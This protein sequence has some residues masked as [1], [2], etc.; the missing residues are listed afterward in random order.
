MADAI[1]VHSAP[2]P[3]KV[4]KPVQASPT[5]D[6]ESGVV[7]EGDYVAKVREGVGAPADFESDAA[8]DEK[9]MPLDVKA[10]NGDIVTKEFRYT[11]R[12]N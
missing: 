11:R 1:P 4:Q 2:K 9:V 12:D 3:V 10:P 7:T 8:A 6:P 5:I